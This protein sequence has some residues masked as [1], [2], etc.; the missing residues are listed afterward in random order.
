MAFWRDYLPRLAGALR[1]P[2]GGVGPARGRL[3]ADPQA[4]L[5]GG[6][7]PG[8]W[9]PPCRFVPWA[10]ASWCLGTLL[11]ASQAPEAWAGAGRDQGD[12][13]SDGTRGKAHARDR[14]GHVGT[15]RGRMTPPMNRTSRVVP[16]RP[17]ADGGAPTGPN[18]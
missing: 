2:P 15:E 3:G 6:L 17:P 11:W 5:R 4:G 16:P 14:G 9:S 8:V 13:T 7:H 10:V 1:R 12:G 18:G